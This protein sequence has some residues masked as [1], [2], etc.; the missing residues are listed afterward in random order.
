MLKNF[1]KRAIIFGS[2]VILLAL[3]YFVFDPFHVLRGYDFY[4]SNFKKTFN[5]NRMSTEMFL[6]NKSKY[7]FKSFI[8]GSSRSSAF[9]TD[10][11]AKYISD[12]TPYHFDSFNDN[13]SGMLGKVEFI[14]KQGSKI[15]NALIVLDKDTFSEQFEE[16]N[17]IVHHKDYRWTDESIFSYHLTFF[18]SYF[19]KQY[20]IYYLDLKINDTYRPA[21]DEFF[22]FKYF[23]SAPFND[24]LF[25][26]NEAQIK[27]DSIGYYQQKE[28]L[29][30]EAN[31][32]PLEAM[33]KIHHVIDLIAL[34]ENLL[35]QKTKFKVVF[36]P[37]FDQRTLNIKDKTLLINLFGQ[38]NFYD[39][40]GK[41]KY[42]N[43]ISNYYE[44]SHFT[45]R[46]GEGIMS[47]I[48]YK[49]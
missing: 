31:P 4:G 14:E 39:Y 23:Y 43:D 19:Q 32:K 15:E 2:P 26:E 40:S 3:S 11:W 28:F 35:R 12:P 13:I 36:S 49:K 29:K 30:R 47:E 46:V 41:N 38:D 33:I 7:N 22:K 17:S 18:K 5:R 21:M 27:K 48:Y 34:K 9:R 25:P 44:L 1:I 20:F 37:M 42:T 10:A 16:S 45:P 6:R 8:F 24:F